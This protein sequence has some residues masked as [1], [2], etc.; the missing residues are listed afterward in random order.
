[1]K[2]K[3]FYLFAMLCVSIAQ[4]TTARVQNPAIEGVVKN[5]NNVGA[6]FATVILTT[7]NSVE[8]AG[9]ITDATGKFVLSAPKGDYT[10]VI[11]HLGYEQY[12]QPIKLLS[13]TAQI[14]NITLNPSTTVM[15]SVEV[16]TRFISREADRFVVN[17]ANS[18][19][20]IGKNALEMLNV[21]PGVWVNDQG[22]SINGKSGVKMI[23]NERIMNLSTDELN[24]YLKNINAEDIQKIE[25]IP[26][27]GADYDADSQSGII[28]ITL[29][30]QRVDGIE[31]NLGTTY[32]I[33]N[34]I[35]EIAPSANINYRSG[36][37]SLYTNLNYSAE[38][39]QNIA[40]E[41]TDYHNS[42]NTVRSGSR[43]DSKNRYY[44]IRL[45]SIYDISAKQNI[46]VEI[47]FS[48]FREPQNTIGI[49]DF[50]TE[51][52][53]TKNNS[54][55][56]S[57]S[58]RNDISATV[59]YLIKL[60]TAGSS[61]KLIGDFTSRKSD[62]NNDYFNAASM[63]MPTTPS[64]IMHSDTTYRSNSASD[65]KI[66]SATANLDLVLSARTKLSSGAK[67]TY[68]HMDNKLLYEGFNAGSENW[69]IDLNQSL[70]NDYSEKIAAAYAIVNT[71][72]SIIKL[73]AGLRGEYTY[74]APRTAQQQGDNTT[75]TTRAKQS[76]FSL[77]PTINISIPGNKRESTLFI[78]AYSRK[79]SR[80]G[81]WALNPFR[82]QLSEYSYISGN[83]SL[84]PTFSNSFTFTSV[85]SHKYS[86]TL[87]TDLI[88][89]SIE[90]RV[91]RDAHNPDI[92]MY[93]HYNSP[94]Q[95]RY[96]I[97]ANLPLTITKWWTLNANLTGINMSYRLTSDSPKKHH[98][99]AY[100]NATNNVTLP[101]NFFIEV[102]YYYQSRWIMG[103]MKSYSTQNVSLSIKKRFAKER[104]TASVSAYNLIKGASN[105]RVEVM[106]EG[107]EK[108]TSMNE[109]WSDRRFVFS[110][111]YNFRS[112]VSFKAKSVESGS[113]EDANRLGGK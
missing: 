107:F 19:A 93:Q 13:G 21:S 23:V 63:W 26:T 96:Y 72:L 51:M 34:S 46:G 30:R 102:S 1:M 110:L 54:N 84:Q 29:K 99:M 90:Q 6:E 79:I 9:A 87:G 28:K 73:S 91:I 111:R 88:H 105:M 55:Y 113:K 24:A 71:R 45:G 98:N 44:G 70:R 86:I 42:Q 83:P 108:Y 65:Y 20:A 69:E 43:I 22:I 94:N 74:A 17:V 80:P 56:H 14:D 78:V 25:V 35:Y 39:T 50:M 103:N 101:K 18:P 100:T 53:T 112:G 5:E 92:L 97:A 77:F 82:M 11:Q 62:E 12:T 76:Y 36:K 31:G 32:M 58:T 27:A 64:D 81:F 95:E 67:F 3:L 59:N 109:N 10:L 52:L 33:G 41:R 61:F 57:I 7:D 66:Y 40:H 47:Y 85:L 89:N 2:R 15:Q 38:K 60:D 48:D 104:F 106:G 75:Q 49:S 68:N 37:L 16:T 8:V 4:T